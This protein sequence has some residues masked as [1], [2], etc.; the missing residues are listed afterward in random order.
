MDNATITGSSFDATY[1]TSLTQTTTTILGIGAIPEGNGTLC[2]LTLTGTPTGLS[3]I[4]VMDAVLVT[5][6]GF[7]FD[8]IETPAIKIITITQSFNEYMDTSLSRTISMT[9]NS[10]AAGEGDINYVLPDSAIEYV[11]DSNGDQI[12]I[13]LTIPASKD[14][15]GDNITI[16]STSLKD[17]SGNAIASSIVIII[18]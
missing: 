4:Q 5:D 16:P 11:W 18:N 7:A 1:I 3:A 14:A 12:T 8:D 13:T 15:R 2:E 17:L 10:T 6:L 9:E